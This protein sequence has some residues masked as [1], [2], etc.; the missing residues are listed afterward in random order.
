MC[1][2][3]IYVSSAHHLVPFVRLISSLC[4]IKNPYFSA[5]QALYTGLIMFKC[6]AQSTCVHHLLAYAYIVQRDIIL[7]LFS[8]SR[9]DLWALEC[10]LSKPANVRRQGPHFV[11]VI[12]VLYDSPKFSIVPPCPSLIWRDMADV[13]NMMQQE[14]T[15]KVKQAENKGDCVSCQH[16]V[17]K[18][19]GEWG[20]V[21]KT[22]D[23]SSGSLDCTLASLSLTD[24]RS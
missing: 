3:L 15:G 11:A 9:G 19:H 24:L 18:R 8:A 17:P 21:W 20:C 5:G 22:H 14:K 10:M 1:K 4:L 12:T 23:A 2:G 7:G 13:K 16:H 6:S